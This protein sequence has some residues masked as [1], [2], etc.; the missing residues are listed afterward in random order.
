MRFILLLFITCLA[1][2]SC[3]NKPTEEDTIT[4]NELLYYELLSE[5]TDNENLISEAKIKLKSV[6]DSTLYKNKFTELEKLSHKQKGLKIKIGDLKSIIGP[7]V[8]RRP[9][10]FCPKRPRIVCCPKLRFIKIG[11]D[12]KDKTKLEILKS[13]NISDEF[14]DDFE[15]IK[16]DGI[17][18][19]EINTKSLG[20]L[21]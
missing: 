6:N 8:K 7:N 11:P 19:L 10:I 2:T 9:C 3:K 4:F 21:E 13:L 16:I 1:I 12:F 17:S 15:L 18:Y 14:K 20:N 5:K